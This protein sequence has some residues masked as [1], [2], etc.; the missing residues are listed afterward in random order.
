MVGDEAAGAAEEQ[1]SVTGMSFQ[2]YGCGIVF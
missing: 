2:Q 1:E